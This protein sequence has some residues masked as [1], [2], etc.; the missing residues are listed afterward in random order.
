MSTV[1]PKL[2]PQCTL[3]VQRKGVEMRGN[4][5]RVRVSAA[6]ALY[7][8]SGLALQTPIGGG[9]AGTVEKS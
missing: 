1:A 2:P 4:V 8:A 9:D 3:D 7:R 5:A 6:H